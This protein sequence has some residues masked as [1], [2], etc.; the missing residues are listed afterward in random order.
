MEGLVPKVMVGGAEAFK[1]TVTATEVLLQ[2][3]DVF[4]RVMVALYVP[5]AAP[6][7]MVIG[8]AFPARD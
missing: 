4:V 8:I 3:V 2:F 7:G 1:V 5:A 6:A